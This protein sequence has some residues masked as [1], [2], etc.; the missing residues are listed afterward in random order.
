MHG[1][2]R[3][4]N[5]ASYRRNWTATRRFHSGTYRQPP[6]WQYR[7][8]TYGSILPALYFAS[9]YWI[10][11]YNSFDLPI[12]PPGTVWVRYGDDALLVDRD[13][14]EVIQVVYGHLRLEL[15]RPGLIERLAQDRPPDIQHK[16][17]VAH[18]VQRAEIGASR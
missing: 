18:V 7:R 17:P 15:F 10:N 12:P 6:G 8:W 14:G 9:S 1:G 5:F 16:R 2:G 4:N 11:N 13:S 3:S